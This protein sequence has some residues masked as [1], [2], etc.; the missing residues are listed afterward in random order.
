MMVN[1]VKEN[2]A[3]ETFCQA[4]KETKAQAH[5]NNNF[6]ECHVRVDSIRMYLNIKNISEID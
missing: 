4:R 3:A 2:N 5:A 6:P 1:V